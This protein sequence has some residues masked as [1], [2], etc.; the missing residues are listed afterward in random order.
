MFPLRCGHL[1]LR[2]RQARAPSRPR[3]PLQMQRNL[4]VVRLWGA[5]VAVMLEVELVKVKGEIQ[6]AC[7]HQPVSNYSHQQSCLTVLI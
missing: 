4:Q 6:A 2:H 3:R 1:H 7:H 5:L